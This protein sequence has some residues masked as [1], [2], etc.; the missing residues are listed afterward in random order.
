MLFFGKKKPKKKSQPETF[1]ELVRDMLTQEDRNTAY[2]EKRIIQQ[3]INSQP[4]EDRF[5]LLVN[6]C[7]E[8][9]KTPDT[10]KNRDYLI[11]I[12]QDR[13]ILGDFFDYPIRFPEGTKRLNEAIVLLYEKGGDFYREK[14]TYS[15]TT[16]FNVNVCFFRGLYRILMEESV[17]TVLNH[18]DRC[19][20]NGKKNEDGTMHGGFGIFYPA[21]DY[22][23]RHKDDI[24]DAAKEDIVSYLKKKSH[25]AGD[26]PAYFRR[27]YLPDIGKPS[28]DTLGEWFEKTYCS[29]N[30]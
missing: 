13:W 30:S 15:A 23:V 7:E 11:D 10:D 25:L 8:G 12:L 18:L 29:V 2:E 5:A 1:E 17:V 27:Y 6:L 14:L 26:L 9:V 19:N 22:S 16:I 24:S 4:M 28:D 3:I 21:F 20:W